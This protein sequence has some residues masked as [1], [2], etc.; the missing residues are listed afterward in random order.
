MPKRSGFAGCA[1]ATLGDRE[2][3]LSTALNAATT[4][5]AASPPDAAIATRAGGAELRLRR[6]PGVDL[7]L[8]LSSVLPDAAPLA[9]D[10]VMSKPG[11]RPGEIAARQGAGQRSRSGTRR[12]DVGAAATRE[13]DRARAWRHVHRS[14]SRSSMTRA[15]ERACRAGAGE[16]A[17]SSE[18]LAAAPGRT[19]RRGQLAPGGHRAAFVRPLRPHRIPEPAR[20][21][22]RRQDRTGPGRQPSRRPWRSCC[23]ATSSQ[24]SCQWARRDRN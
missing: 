9:F 11:T 6:D 24:S 18:P 23:E 13:P 16:R 7:F 4:G 22:R 15:E 10:A 19:C 1:R 20:R 3:A 14:M 8:P 17:S 12:T 21:H 5:R 2:F